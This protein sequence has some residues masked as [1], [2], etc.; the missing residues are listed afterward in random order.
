MLRGLPA[1]SCPP[2]ARARSRSGSG[3]APGP[4]PLLWPPSTCALPRGRRSPA[5]RG[6]HRP[7]AGAGARG[8]AARPGSAPPGPAWPG[9]AAT[10]GDGGGA[11]P[12]APRRAASPRPLPHRAPGPLPAPPAA[13]RSPMDLPA[14]LETPPGSAAPDKY[15]YLYTLLAAPDKYISPPSP[16]LA[17][18][19]PPTCSGS[20]KP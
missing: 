10:G 17:A 11:E 13:E 3:A 5:R 2:G 15:K 4:A 16:Y 8:G 19:G 9:P 7:P 14:T 12:R 20:G 6:F 18:L 1:P